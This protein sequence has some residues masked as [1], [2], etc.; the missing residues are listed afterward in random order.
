MFERLQE[1]RGLVGTVGRSVGFI[2][3]WR[4]SC[5]RQ[6]AHPSTFTGVRGGWL[7]V[8]AKVEPLPV[9]Q[10]AFGAL[11]LANN[12]WYA[13]VHTSNSICCSYRRAGYL[14]IYQCVLCDVGF[15][16]SVSL[17]NLRFV[18]PVP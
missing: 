18:C 9:F 16:L 10:E 13:F 4:S 17:R 12:R 8:V 11:P 15:C 3:C 1:C 5:G 2:Q 6:C 7:Q 14:S